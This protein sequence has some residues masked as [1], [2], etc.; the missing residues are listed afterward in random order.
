LVA[1]SD[2]NWKW[3]SDAKLFANGDRKHHSEPDGQSDR[4]KKRVT[5]AHGN[6]KR[7]WNAN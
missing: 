7:R 1:V 2:G 3:T 5:V 6:E 4:N